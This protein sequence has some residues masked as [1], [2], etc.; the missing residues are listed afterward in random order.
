MDYDIDYNVTGNM[1]FLDKQKFLND[2]QLQ[3][4]FIVKDNNAELKIFTY[5]DMYWDIH[6]KLPYQ[7]IYFIAGEK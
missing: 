7:M 5:K 1:S 4:N 3:E 2:I 6:S